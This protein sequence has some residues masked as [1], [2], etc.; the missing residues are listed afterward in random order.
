MRAG[1][2]WIV[3][4][5]GLIAWGYFQPYDSTDT[6]PNRSGVVPLTDGLTGCQYLRTPWPSSI[7]PRMGRDGK[8]ICVDATPQSKD[9]TGV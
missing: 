9:G 5:F 4:S 7:T 2:F 8:Q 6:P 1:I 3:V